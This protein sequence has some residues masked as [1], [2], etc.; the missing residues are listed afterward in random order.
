MNQNKLANLT[1]HKSKNKLEKHEN[2]EVAPENF[3]ITLNSSPI[4]LNK[5]NVSTN[6]TNTLYT[7]LFL[8]GYYEMELESIIFSKVDDMD[9]GSVSV[10]CENLS[11]GYMGRIFY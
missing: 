10:Y 3:Y 2:V 1:G 8:K 6:F 9:L 5:N 11:G 7:P 4:D